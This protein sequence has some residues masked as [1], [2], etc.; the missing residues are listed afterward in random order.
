[1]AQHAAREPLRP[2]KVIELWVAESTVSDDFEGHRTG[3]APLG[4]R[5][6]L[7][8]QGEV[9]QWIVR[10]DADAA[11]GGKVLMQVSDD[12]TNYRLP[13][14]VYDYIMA[15]DVDVSVQFKPISGSVDQ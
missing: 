2:A 15:R 13:V 8:G 14:L 1:M 12:P 6:A 11:S 4:F 5:T 3:S 9:G 10:D 7:T